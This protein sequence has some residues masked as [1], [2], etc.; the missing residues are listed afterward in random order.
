MWQM[1]SSCE[2]KR[3]KPGDF[4]GDGCIMGQV[5]DRQILLV[6]LLTE[7]SNLQALS[8]WAHTLIGSKYGIPTLI[9][10]LGDIAREEK[11]GF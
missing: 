9:K 7:T 4:G 1:V 10:E 5:G 8:F 3:V 6:D 2:G 11:N